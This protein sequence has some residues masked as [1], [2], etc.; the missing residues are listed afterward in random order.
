MY[1]HNKIICI[2]R[3]NKMKIILCAIFVSSIKIF[4][5]NYKCETKCNIQYIKIEKCTLLRIIYCVRYI[6]IIR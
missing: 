4:N 3:T 1:T 2:K 5:T 6:V